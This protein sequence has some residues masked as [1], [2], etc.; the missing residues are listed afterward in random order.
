[1][2]PFAQ[3]RLRGCSE[4]TIIL[5]VDVRDGQDFPTMECSCQRDNVE[6][7]QAG[8]RSPWPTFVQTQPRGSAPSSS[9]PPSPLLLPPGRS[10][11]QVGSRQSSVGSS[12]SEDEKSELKTETFRGGQSWFG[13]RPAACTAPSVP[14]ATPTG[15]AKEILNRG[16]ATVS[17]VFGELMALLSGYDLGCFVQS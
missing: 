3:R 6:A 5:G 4:T 7:E 17:R 11:G 12:L 8:E 2:G 1:M 9:S 16:S 15:R 14:G 10:Q 13:G